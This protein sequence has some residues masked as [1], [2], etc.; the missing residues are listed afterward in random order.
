M[1]LPLSQC[2]NPGTPFA[3]SS[4]RVWWAAW[5][6][7]RTPGWSLCT[8]SAWGRAGRFLCSRSPERCVAANSGSG[9]LPPPPFTRLFDSGVSFCSWWGFPASYDVAKP[10]VQNHLRWPLP[11]SPSWERPWR[12][13]PDFKLRHLSCWSFRRFWPKTILLLGSLWSSWPFGRGLQVRGQPAAFRR[14]TPRYRDAHSFYLSGWLL[15]AKETIW[16]YWQRLTLS[17]WITTNFT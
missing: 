14:S 11:M 9:S 16:Y 2:P 15:H 7:R 5:F 17:E 13:P 4:R 3:A 6:L 12:A 10:V 8:W 1:L